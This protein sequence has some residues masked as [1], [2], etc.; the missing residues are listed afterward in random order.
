MKWKLFFKAQQ[1]ATDGEGTLGYKLG[2]D[3]TIVK[4]A[5]SPSAVWFGKFREIMGIDLE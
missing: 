4:A 2:P 3:D 5:G 1:E